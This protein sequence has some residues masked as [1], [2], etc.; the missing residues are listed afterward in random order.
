MFA[1][2]VG[3][4]KCFILFYGY[5][6]QTVQWNILENR[7]DTRALGFDIRMALFRVLGL[8]ITLLI[9]LKRNIS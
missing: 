4:S 5:P 6:M 3:L 1:I 7:T 8:C 9:H 2:L